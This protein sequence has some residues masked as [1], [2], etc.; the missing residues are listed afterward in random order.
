MDKKAVA[1][2]FFKHL[3]VILLVTLIVSIGFDVYN[4]WFK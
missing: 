4:I 1:D 2:K 3:D